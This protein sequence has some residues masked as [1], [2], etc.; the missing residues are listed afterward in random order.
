MTLNI[1]MHSKAD[2]QSS[3]SVGESHQKPKEGDTQSVK[4]G[5]ILKV[6][7][8]IQWKGR[9]PATAGARVRFPVWEHNISSDVLC[10]QSRNMIK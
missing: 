9:W 6:H 8:G 10:S 5:D 4:V 7:W 1:G 3:K 2:L